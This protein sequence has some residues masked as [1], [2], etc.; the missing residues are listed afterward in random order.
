MN[1]SEVVTDCISSEVL[2]PSPFF[3]ILAIGILVFSFIS[4]MSVIVTCFP[5]AVFNLYWYLPDM[6][7]LAVIF[8]LFST[9]VLLPISSHLS[10]HLLSSKV[11]ECEYD[12]LSPL[13]VHSIH[14]EIIEIYYTPPTTGISNKESNA[15]LSCKYGGSF[16]ILYSR[17]TL[18]HCGVSF[19][20][21]SFSE[22]LGFSFII[23]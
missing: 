17:I 10:N 1:I 6:S 3:Y 15:I 2:L 19:H 11:P 18:L 7:V 22:A 16:S 4:W 21:G 9:S 5:V 23:S 14:N 8:L 12:P 20:P 13:L